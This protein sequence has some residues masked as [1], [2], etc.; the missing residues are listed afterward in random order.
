MHRTIQLLFAMFLLSVSAW[1]Q[2][3]II[4]TGTLNTNSQPDPL[5]RD[6]NFMHYQVVY[7]QTQ[8]VA[9][10]MPAG[11]SILALGFS[12]TQ[13]PG[14]LSNFEISLGHTLQATANPYISS[15]LT[16]VKAPFTYLPVVK[17]CREFRYDHL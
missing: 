13:S 17:N 14:N 9:A 6:K 7:T 2:S 15:G 12:V 4:G 16:Q 5:D 1:G 3:A 11:A 8:L 10:G